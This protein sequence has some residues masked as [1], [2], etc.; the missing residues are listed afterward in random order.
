[1]LRP[2]GRYADAWFPAFPHRPEDYAKRL[3]IVRAAASDAGRDPMSILPAIEFLVV[4]GPSRGAVD[5]AL[6]SPVLKA[7]S[8][9][10]S[11]EAATA[12]GIRWEKGFRVRRTSCRTRS[13]KRQHCRSWLMFRHR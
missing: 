4:T 13:M 11:D 12:P 6:D 5:E 10:A 7:L 8:P 2:T 1:M 9:T 3:E